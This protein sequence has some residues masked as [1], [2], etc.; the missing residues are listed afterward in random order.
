M[1]YA[2]HIMTNPI[3]LIMNSNVLSLLCVASMDTWYCSQFIQRYWCFFHF[4]ILNVSFMVYL[5]LEF[6]SF[7]EGGAV[8]HKYLLSVR[9]YIS[10]QS[11]YP[12]TSE[13][14]YF[15]NRSGKRACSWRYSVRVYRKAIQDDEWSQILQIMKW[16]FIFHSSTTPVT[17]IGST[18]T[19]LW[20]IECH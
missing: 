17:W 3:L 9:L 15:N 5:L 6:F 16:I 7:N 12:I 8:G 4:F 20:S 14:T 18:F 19:K 1:L 11:M 10:F 13:C 2:R